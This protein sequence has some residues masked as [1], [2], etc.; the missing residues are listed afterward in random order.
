MDDR[1]IYE[2]TRLKLAYNK[3]LIF[4]AGLI[5]F[6]VIGVLLYIWNIY[7]YNFSL[8]IIGVL[9]IVTGLIGIFTIDQKIK[10]ISEKIKGL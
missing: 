2:L 9:I 6:T 7:S 8:F 1:K 3:Q 10:L 4:I 5:I